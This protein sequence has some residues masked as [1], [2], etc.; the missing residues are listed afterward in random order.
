M[1]NASKPCVTSGLDEMLAVYSTIFHMYQQPGAS[2][3]SY[4]SP[5]VQKQIPRVTLSPADKLS[6]CKLVQHIILIEA[7]SETGIK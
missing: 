3:V 1:D 2:R 7:L 6:S 5:R 4:L